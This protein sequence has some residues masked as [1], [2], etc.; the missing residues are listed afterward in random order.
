M[1]KNTPSPSKSRP[2]VR[3]TAPAIGLHWLIGLLIVTM[4]AMGLIMT[5]MDMSAAKF[6]LY[7]NHKSLGLLILLLVFVRTF[8]RFTH[9]AP[10]LPKSMP[11][12]Q[13]AA[14]H[15]SHWLLYILMFAMPISGWLFSDA[16]GYHPSL[17]GIPVPVIAQQN[18]DV[19]EFFSEFHE[20]AAFTLI[21][22]IVLHV[23]AALHHHVIHK[24]DILLRMLPQKA[25]KKLGLVLL[26]TLPLT[27]HAG[28]WHVD[29]TTSS[30][31]W[32]VNYNG[33]PLKGIFQ[34]WNAKVF[35]EPTY[36][37]VSTLEVSVKTGSIHSGDFG[38]DSTIK[39]EEWFDVIRYPYATFK[40]DI[41]TKVG[42][43]KYV[44][45]GKFTLIGITRTIKVPFTLEIN[46]TKARAKGAFALL[47][48]DFIL[49]K[50][51]W[52][53]SQEIDNQVNVY[54]TVNAEAN[55]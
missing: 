40:S 3:Y 34:D 4:L 17:F 39:G 35:F 20:L 33:V 32:Q 53:K 43:N 47:R 2:V 27:A 55:K 45:L 6:A 11:T 9:P 21:G 22:L 12:W 52:E 18:R 37:E 8:W 50:G 10:M 26:L 42:E 23:G 5:E 16:A 54:F 13:K 44:A 38:R 15:G 36:P 30:L 46:G 28:T 29:P 51:P 14:A 24:D 19:A 25:A 49:G 1:K 48:T 41:I 7:Q 31:R